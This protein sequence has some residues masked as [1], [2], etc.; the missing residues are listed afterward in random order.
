MGINDQLVQDYDEKVG[1]YVRFC[2]RIRFILEDL[3][4]K[5]G[6]YI[7]SIHSRTKSKKSFI[8]KINRP[9]VSYKDISDVTDIAG[10]RV[11][12]YFSSDVDK[13]A[14]IVKRK[15]IIDHENSTDKRDIKDPDRFGYLSL[16]YVVNLK[17]SDMTKTDC[18]FL[19]DLKAEIQIRSILQHAWAEIEHDLGYKSKYSIPFDM[20]RRFSRL[21][22]LL[23]LADEEFNNLRND[24]KEY[25]EKIEDSDYIDKYIDKISLNSFI[26]R[27]ELVKDIDKDISLRTGLE[28]EHEE[29]FIESLVEKLKYV[30]IKDFEEL[31]INLDKRMEVVKRFAEDHLKGRSSYSGIS[32]GVCIYY[33]CTVI[34]AETGDESKMKGYLKTF[35]LGSNKTREKF[36]QKIIEKYRAIYYEINGISI[37]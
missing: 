15:F 11:T 7:N 25:K 19:K 34:C 14:E 31:M 26:E 1:Y 8:K 9:D 28:L 27:S 37:E 33:L 30:G 10:L 4:I 12:T 6:L 18:N 16:H 20:R 32:T 21:S 22:G 29:W 35:Q 17:P 23:E 2:E 24:L 13:V 36:A 3:I 5:E